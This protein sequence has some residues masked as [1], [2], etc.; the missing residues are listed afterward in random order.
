MKT[1]TIRQRLLQSTMIGGAALFAATAL[2]VAA[3][4][5]TPTAVSAQD[6]TNGT[7]SGAVTD[8]S[9]APVSGASVTVRS[10]EQ[11][12]TRN[13][14]TDA[15]GR[16]RAPQIPIGSYTVTITAPGHGTEVQTASVRLGSESAYTFV[17]TSGGATNVEDVVVTGA[18]SALAFS[19][20]TTGLTV[21]LEELVKTVPIGRDITSVTLLAPSTVQGDSA[22]GNVPSVGGS[23]VAE[24]AF[25]V[26]GLNITN[27]DN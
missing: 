7:L 9:G 26:N 6:Y 16:F 13:L 11:G 27:F 3:V 23:S 19:E 25:Y 18:R 15:S 24:N 2:P 8:E 1:Q 10:N 4:M 22:F 20:T 21:D 17:L 14:T 12:L 5:L